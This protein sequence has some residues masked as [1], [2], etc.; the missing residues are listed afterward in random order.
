MSALTQ[1]FDVVC[2]RIRRAV[3]RSGRSDDAVRLVAISKWHEADAVAELAAHWSGTGEPLF[4]ESYAQEAESKIPRVAA[5][6]AQTAPAASARWHFVGHLQSRKAK[7]VVGGFDLIHS[8]DSVK[9]A[10]AMQKAWQNHAALTPVGLNDAAPG[11]QAV[12]LQVNVGRE[13]QKS[14]LDPDDLE[15][16]LN[17]I[18]SIPELSVEGLMCLPPWVEDPEQSRPYFIMLRELRGRLQARCGLELPHLSMGMSSDFEAAIEEGATLV[19]IG[20]DIFGPRG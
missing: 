15:E 9:L 18:V 10:L 2:E 8:V 16:A 3:E 14:G 7:E 6:L 13:A 20:T 12:L 1:R 4:G 5:R 11:P 19:R 17:K